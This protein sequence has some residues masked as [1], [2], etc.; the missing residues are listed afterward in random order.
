MPSPMPVLEVDSKMLVGNGSMQRYL[1]EMYGLA[2]SNARENAKIDSI[3][4][5]MNYLTVS[6]TSVPTILCSQHLQRTL[7]LWRGT[8]YSGVR[9]PGDSLLWGIFYFVAY[10]YLVL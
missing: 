2:A 9:W 1:A 5:T 8:L 6:P 3:V 10:L 4:N 7:L